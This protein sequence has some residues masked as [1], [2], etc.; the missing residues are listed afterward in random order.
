MSGLSMACRG[1][2][3]LKVYYGDL[4]NHCEVGYGHGSAESAY[5]NAITQLDFASVTAHT[6]W[7]DMPKEERLGLAG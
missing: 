1:F 4:H 7:P 5:Q 3:G 6:Q 2:E